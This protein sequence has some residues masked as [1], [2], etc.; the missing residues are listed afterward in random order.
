MIGSM[1]VRK[2]SNDQEDSNSKNLF[3]RLIDSSMEELPAELNDRRSLKTSREH[4]L[5]DSSFVDFHLL[6]SPTG[7]IIHGLLDDRDPGI[8]R[9]VEIED[10]VDHHHLDP[11]MSLDL[12]MVPVF[13]N[14]KISQMASVNG[15]ICLH[16]DPRSP[17]VD[18][19]YICNPITRECMILPRQQHYT[20][21]I[22]HY[23]FGVS[24]HT[25]EYKV[26]R[27][28]HKTMDLEAEVYTLG[29]GQWR[30]VGHVPYLLSKGYPPQKIC[31]FDLDKELNISI[32]SFSS[33][34]IC[35][36]VSDQI[37]RFGSL[38]GF[39]VVITQETIDDTIWSLWAPITLIDVLKDRSILIVSEYEELWTIDPRSGT[40]KYT[41]M[42]G[43][44]SSGDDLSSELS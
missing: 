2:P 9:L 11:L 24:S 3:I 30:N 43:L 16:Q 5:S 31:T 20:G 42:F 29:I 38:K 33:Y 10:K 36:W 17:K 35:T 22:Y 21:G 34:Q 18:N 4:H 28:F 13:Q 25:G 32:V 7:L 37:P 1:R 12:N 26:V 8:F 23:G 27:T 14:S 39:P 19:T 6:R 15:L 44:A 40:I 41:K